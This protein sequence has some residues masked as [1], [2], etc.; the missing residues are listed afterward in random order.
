MKNHPLCGW[1]FIAVRSG[2]SAGVALDQIGEEEPL[3]GVGQMLVAEDQD[4]RFDL[5][6]GALAEVADASQLLVLDHVDDLTDVEHVRPL[7]GVARTNGEVQ[8]VQRRL[9][10]A[11]A[12][13]DADA[14]IALEHRL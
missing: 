6:L 7:E 12:E 13:G 8:L 5:A 10:L 14:D 11:L 4:A 1:I 3:L 2:P 9:A